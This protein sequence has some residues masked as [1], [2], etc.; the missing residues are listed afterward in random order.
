M[1]ILENMLPFGSQYY[2]APTPTPEKWDDDLCEMSKNGFNTIKILA[3]WGWNNPSEGTYDF[4]DIDALMDIAHKYGLKVIINILFDCA[5]EWFYAKYPESLMEHADGSLLYPRAVG[6]RSIGG[7]PGPCYHHGPGTKIREE[8]L[9][10]IAARYQ[11]HPA[12][13]IWDLWNE[14]ELTC[15]ISR[16][17]KEDKLVCYCADSIRVFRGWLS[18]KYG[19]IENINEAWHR[20]Y[21]SMDEV[22]APRC[23][24]TFS[25]MIDWR[26]FFADTIARELQM[27]AEAIK[28][29]DKTHP[30]MAHIVPM[31]YFN[32][33]TACCDDFA[34]AKLCDLFGNSIG[35]SPFAAQW[36]TSAANGKIC[37]NSEIH[38]MGG[39][40]L[41]PPAIPSFNDFA[42]H[43]LIPLSYGIKGF[44]FWQYRPESL[45][46]ESPAWGLCGSGGEMTEWYRYSI[47]INNALQKRKDLLL[48]ASPPK[49]EIA[50]VASHKNQIFNFCCANDINLSYSALAGAQSLLYDANINSDIICAEHLSPEILDKYKAIYY[51]FPYYMAKNVAGLLKAYV[52]GGGIL[53]SE[54]FFGAYKDDGY[55]SPATPGFGMDTLF[56]V[57]ETRVIQSDHVRLVPG[58]AQGKRYQEELKELENSDTA[59]AEIIARFQN[60]ALAVSANGYGKGKAIYIGTLLSCAYHETKDADTL[61]F[62]A[63]LLGAHG[64]APRAWCDNPGVRADVQNGEKGAAVIFTNRANA[65]IDTQFYLPGDIGIASL[66]DI[67]TGETIALEPKNGYLCGRINMEARACRCLAGAPE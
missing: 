38:A 59:P 42:R 56:G 62:V 33:A 14:P 16:D 48:E 45:G 23:G 46:L 55:H 6:H 18:Q 12:M 54:A 51:P 64:I 26:M 43:I 50:I 13:Y 52:E 65:G 57:R 2:R 4:S 8:F 29:F 66:A 28:R 17:V 24:A 37:I 7:A 61:N 39:S 11:S 34:M 22:P 9:V 25:D 3:Q 20:R 19:G 41:N 36:T 5:P 40:T 21:N 44:V 47:D 67:F 32:M 27:R 58:D 35:S 60:G 10:R 1:N 53:I 63:S 15:G 31:P 30:V 49:S